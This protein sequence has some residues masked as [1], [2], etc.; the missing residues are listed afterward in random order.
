VNAFNNILHTEGVLPTLQTQQLLSDINRV[1]MTVMWDLH[2]QIY[3][4]EPLAETQGV[5]IQQVIEYGNR[6]SGTIVMGPNYLESSLHLDGFFRYIGP[7]KFET[8]LDSSNVN[9]L[10]ID[11]G[12]NIR[13]LH[14]SET[15]RKPL[16]V[17]NDLVAEIEGVHV[18]LVMLWAE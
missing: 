8:L 15:P 16:V 13:R 17:G 18:A 3:A 1:P 6:G 2:N 5:S 11:F 12:K 4:E 10:S 7:H 9:H 14:A